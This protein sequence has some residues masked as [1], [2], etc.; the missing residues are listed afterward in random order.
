MA[1]LQMHL[2]SNVLGRSVQADVILPSVNAQPSELPTLFLLHGMTDD[3]SQW[4]RRTSLERYA[5]NCGMAVVLPDA[6]LSFY[7]NTRSG[8][9]YFDYISEEL[10]LAVRR[11]LP[12]LSHRRDQNFVAGL[13]M[14]G[15]GALKCALTHPETFSKAAALSAALDVAQLSLNPTP[16]GRPY[17]W[18]DVFGSQAEIQGSEND[19]FALAEKISGDNRPKIW[20]WCGTEDS[21]YSMNQR[22]QAHLSGLGYAVQFHASAG[23]HDWAC[24]DREICNALI[25]LANGEEGAPCL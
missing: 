24:W 2:Y 18:E 8:E 15:Y 16:L 9:A 11:A 21:L 14:G 19:L 1:L 20:M 5:E 12:R 7:A 6:M 13:S 10:V 25:W 22:M 4:L 17:C 3:H 23:G